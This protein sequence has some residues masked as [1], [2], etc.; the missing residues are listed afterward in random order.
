MTYDHNGGRLRRGR[1][2]AGRGVDSGQSSA[3][4]LDSSWASAS[5]GRRGYHD[6]RRAFMVMIVCADFG[7][8]LVIVSGPSS[9]YDPSSGSLSS[10]GDRVGMMRPCKGEWEEN[11]E[12][13]S[14]EHFG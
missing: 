5:H 4:S 2:N 9:F 8:S 13:G 7:L 11:G 14:D 12:E 3:H 10:M 6:S 1:S